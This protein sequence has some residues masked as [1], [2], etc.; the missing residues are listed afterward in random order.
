MNQ[1]IERIENKE[2]SE[3][4]LTLVNPAYWNDLVFYFN[5]L[6]HGSN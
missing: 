1:T 3:L 2:F 5:L 4:E 6:N